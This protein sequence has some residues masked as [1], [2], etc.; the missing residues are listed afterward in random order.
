MS[1]RTM[2]K[3]LYAMFCKMICKISFKKI[4]LGICSEKCCLR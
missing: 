3:A 2:K 4:C 1:R